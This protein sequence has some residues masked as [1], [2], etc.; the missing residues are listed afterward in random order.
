MRPPAPWTILDV[1]VADHAGAFEPALER[2]TLVLL[3]FRGVLLGEAQLLPS[4]VPMT[5]AEFATLVAARIGPTA[6]GLVAA[7]T[8]ER[9][10]VD[11]PARHRR[12]DVLTPDV[13]TQL[14]TALARSRARPVTLSAS[15]LVTARGRPAELQTCLDTLLPELRAGREVIVVDNR[16][17]AASRA[18]AASVAGVRYVAAPAAGADRTVGAGIRAAGGEVVVLLG[19]DDRPEPGWADALLA[20]FDSAGV[21]LVCGLVLPAALETD[22]QVAAR[23]DLGLGLT[24]SVPL[25][26][27]GSAAGHDDG[28]G[29]SGW[30][31]T[32]VG[33]GAN[34]AIRRDVAL[35]LGLDRLTS[36]GEVE[37]FDHVLAAGA[38]VRYEPLSVLHHPHVRD[39][40]G[41][42]TLAR[43]LARGQV[44]ATERRSPPGQHRRE[45]FVRLAGLLPGWYGHRIVRAPVFLARGVPD[46]LLTSSLRGYAAGVRQQAGRQHHDP[47][48]QPRRDG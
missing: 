3:R 48:G 47:V 1:D 36:G 6:V 33:A 14:D 21:G 10:V 19:D 32:A 27:D 31:A 9:A 23:Y 17:G 5:A 42:R 28:H 46:R 39:W 43:R 2:P 13:L 35:R 44:I 4:D 40:P 41:L 22:A 16:P 11:D 37:V 15:I 24:G 30:V 12:L 45:T 8:T 38:Q 18:V 7:E 20:G 26:F 34:L 29:H 25:R